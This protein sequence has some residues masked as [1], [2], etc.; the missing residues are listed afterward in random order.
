[1]PVI[2]R[3]GAAEIILSGESVATGTYEVTLDQSVPTMGTA[4][5]TSAKGVIRLRFGDN[6]HRAM[7]GRTVRVRFDGTVELP[8]DVTLYVPAAGFIAFTCS[9]ASGLLA[10]SSSF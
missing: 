3:T 1:V 9:E 5:R 8:V 2:Q 4:R 7:T 6:A 10:E